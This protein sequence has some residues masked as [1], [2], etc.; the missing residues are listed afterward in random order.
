MVYRDKD[1]THWPYED[2]V[3]PIKIATKPTDTI[4]ME[5]LSGKL[6]L[7]TRRRFV[8]G[9]G[10]V[11]SY[12]YFVDYVRSGRVADYLAGLDYFLT[13]NVHCGPVR[14]LPWNRDVTFNDGRY[15]VVVDISYLTNWPIKSSV[16]SFPQSSLVFD[17]CSHGIRELL[18]KVHG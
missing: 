13:S 4:F 11:N 1:G 7:T 6:A 15:Q 2:F 14:A 3:E 8:S 16:L 18:F 17:I 9:D 12:S 5:D 10:L